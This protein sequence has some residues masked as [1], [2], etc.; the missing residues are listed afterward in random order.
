MR[1]AGKIHCVAERAEV[2]RDLSEASVARQTKCERRGGSFTFVARVALNPAGLPSSFGKPGVCGLAEK[3]VV[4]PALKWQA[5]AAVARWSC[6]TFR[7]FCRLPWNPARQRGSFVSF[8]GSPFQGTRLGPILR[9]SG[10][11]AVQPTTKPGTPSALLLVR[12]RRPF[13]PVHPDPGFAWPYINS[14]GPAFAQSTTRF[15][16]ET[17]YFCTV[18]AQRC[19]VNPSIETN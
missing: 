5:E 6:R 13:H 19:G 18:L 7:W 15:G 1:K 4:P 10:R 11:T 3:P 2:R 8:G 14:G 17:W 12:Q 9:E 16:T